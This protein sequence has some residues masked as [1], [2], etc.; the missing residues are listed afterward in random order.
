MILLSCKSKLILKDIRE[1]ILKASSFSSKCAVV[2]I[3]YILFFVV[4]QWLAAVV[5][6]KNNE[7]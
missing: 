4:A 2:F 6:V 7:F 5:V 3:I 1:R